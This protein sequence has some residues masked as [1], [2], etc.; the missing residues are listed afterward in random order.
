M[1][2]L[3]FDYLTKT[4]AQMKATDRGDTQAAA[5]CRKQ[6]AAAWVGMNRTQ[7]R[8]AIVAMY[9]TAEKAGWVERK[10]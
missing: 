1:D 2:S 5:E 6:A 4:L 3:V 9:A 10:A 7:R 8:A